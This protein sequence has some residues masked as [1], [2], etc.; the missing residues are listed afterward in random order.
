VA[1]KDLP[2]T[3]EELQVFIRMVGPRYDNAKKVL[4]I[5]CKRFPNRIENKRFSVL[6][7]ERL[8]AEARRL[9]AEGLEY[10]EE[11]ENK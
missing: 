7:L 5:I 1:A 3:P 10:E 8:L 11:K 9:T 4:R 6:L 2:L